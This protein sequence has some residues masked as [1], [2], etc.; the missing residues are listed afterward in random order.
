MW[1]ISEVLEDILGKPKK[2]FK[3]RNSDFPETVGNIFQTSFQKVFVKQQER[4]AL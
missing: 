4:P 2:E 1:G 3:S